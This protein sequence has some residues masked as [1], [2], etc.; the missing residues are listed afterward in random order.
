MGNADEARVVQPLDATHLF[1]EL[2]AADYDRRVAVCSLLLIV[3]TRILVTVFKVARYNELELP[4]TPLPDIVNAWNPASRSVWRRRCRKY[5]RSSLCMF[6]Q[7]SSEVSIAYTHIWVSVRRH[8]ELQTI[9]RMSQAVFDVYG[10]W[11]K[12]WDRHWRVCHRK[13]RSLRFRGSSLIDSARM[14]Y[15]PQQGELRP[16]D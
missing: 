13:T 14:Q 16:K 5:M 15:K 8:Y 11:R 1:N 9:D 2:S 10:D 3:C 7:E 12:F 6:R 4:S